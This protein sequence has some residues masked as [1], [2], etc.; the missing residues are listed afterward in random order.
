MQKV[1]INMHYL[2]G[3]RDTSHAPFNISKELSGLSELVAS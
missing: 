3:E 1:K 2:K